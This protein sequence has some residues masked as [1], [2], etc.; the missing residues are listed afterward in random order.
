MANA[1]ILIQEPHY[2]HLL[3][4]NIANTTNRFQP[5]WDNVDWQGKVFDWIRAEVKKLGYSLTG[6]PQN[7]HA[8]P[9]STV[10]QVPTDH[11]NLFFKAGGPTQYFEPAL[12][13][14]LTDRWPQQTLP[15][16]AVNVEKGWSLQ[17]D[18]GQTL[19]QRLQGK[20]DF[21]IWQR[22]LRDYAKLQIAAAQWQSE[23]RAC[24]VPV[25]G[26]DT[27]IQAYTEILTDPDLVLIGE[28]EDFLTA[29][30]YQQLLAL[31]PK[32][33]EL[34]TELDRYEIPLS[35]EHGDFHD[36]NI[37]VQDDHY[38]FFDWGDASLTHP[39]FTLLIPFRH[40]A[41]KLGVSEYADHTDLISLRDSYLDPWKKIVSRD[42]LKR[43]WQLAH[44]L[45][46]FVRTINWYRVVKATVPNLSNQY[47]ASVGGWFLEFLS[48][49]FELT[50]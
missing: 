16:L 2:N 24:G 48:H 3:I 11:G 25:Y 12:L 44:Y 45:A 38:Y 43:S 20:A 5:P 4:M 28:G 23:I 27:L 17:P 8:R 15:V 6:E 47:Q 19:R 10:L 33:Q 36:A 18:G 35:I 22:L 50:G 34:F 14:L 21:K 42:H 37:F 26:I 31:T 41:D 39:F 9:W 13:Q 30:Q 49:P 1:T 40:L 46:K 32:V 7:I 29:D